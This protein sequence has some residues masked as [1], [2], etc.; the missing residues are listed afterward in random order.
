[1]KLLVCV[2][3]YNEEEVII[4]TVEAIAHE[5]FLLPGMEWHIVVADN[6]STDG[7]AR[8]LREK[9]FPYASVL[10]VA[11]KGKGRAIRESAEYADADLFCFIDADLSA[12]PAYI[13]HLLREIRQGA[14]VAFGSRL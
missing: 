6:A 2:P 14:D 4:P 5:L 9:N 1:M 12:D 13:A 10:F 3:A 8:R 11:Q 7:T